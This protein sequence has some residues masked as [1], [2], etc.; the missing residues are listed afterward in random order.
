MNS[1]TEITEKQQS[2]A[3]RAVWTV[4]RALIGFGLAGYLIHRLISKAEIDLKAEFSA[5]GWPSYIIALLCFGGIL[6]ICF[7]RWRLLLAVQDVNLSYLTVVR[8][9]MIGTFFNLVLPGAVTGDIVKMAYIKQHA[10]K[11]TAEAILTIML[12]RV[13]GLFGLFIVAAGACLAA[14]DFIRN[15]SPLLQ[16]ATSIVAI[17]CV[18]GICAILGAVFHRGLE[19]LP[20]AK[21]LIGLGRR[22]LPEKIQSLVGR[23]VRAVDLYRDHKRTFVCAVLLSVAVHCLNGF[24]L[25]AVGRAV[26]VERGPKLRHYFVAIQVGNAVGSIP[27]T[28]SG[29]GTRDVVIQRFLAQADTEPEK[30]SAVV[31]VFF[32]LVFTTW[33]LSGGLVFVASRYG[34]TTEDSAGAPPDTDTPE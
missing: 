7:Y 10:G 22:Y 8:L 32:S 9:G 21:Q 20:V 33:F 11:R 30:K 4:V 1:P 6:A 31:P 16:G 15:A 14:H 19:Q 13:I 3:R 2:S 27:A 18:G 17:G 23:V 28:P 25:Y 26:H 24:A 34:G 29:Y 5:L 12:D